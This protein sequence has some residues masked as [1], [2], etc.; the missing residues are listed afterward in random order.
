MDKKVNTFLFILG[1]TLFNILVTIVSFVLLVIIYV[2][3][4][5]RFIPESVQ[6]QAWPYVI[7]F[8]GAIAVSFVVY[9]YALRFLLKKI[10]V[11]K[12]FDPLFGPRRK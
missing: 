1:A 3:L 9:R 7:I 6:L 2:K 8:I 12:H 11:D 10:D 5:E 4:I